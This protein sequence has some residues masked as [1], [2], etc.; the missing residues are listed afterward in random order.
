MPEALQKLAP[1]LKGDKAKEGLTAHAPLPGGD[2]DV[3]SVD[4]LIAE[5]LRDYPFLTPAH[6]SRAVVVA[7]RATGRGRAQSRGAAASGSGLR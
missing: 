2:F 7:R 5:I 4:A 6:A 3:S 1:Y